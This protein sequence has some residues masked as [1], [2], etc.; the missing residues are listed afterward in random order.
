MALLTTYCLIP[1]R[2]LILSVSHYRTLILIEGGPRGRGTIIGEKA[3]LFANRFHD[4]TCVCLGTNPNH[5]GSMRNSDHVVGGDTVEGL[6]KVCLV[7]HAMF[8]EVL[9]HQFQVSTATAATV[10]QRAAHH[11]HHD[12]TRVIKRE[13]IPPEGDVHPD[14]SGTVV[15]IS[16][17]WGQVW[18]PSRPWQPREPPLHGKLGRTRAP[19]RIWISSL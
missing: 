1:L 17:F 12:T 16:L 4:Y 18:V 13:S 8:A 10:L 2:Y 9:P 11:A 6:T 7:P 5:N 14:P 3:L 15:Q 19:I